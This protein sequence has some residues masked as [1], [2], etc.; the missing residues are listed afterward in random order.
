MTITKNRLQKLA[1]L[2]VEQK[3]E[4]SSPES[5]SPSREDEEEEYARHKN[6]EQDNGEENLP[7]EPGFYW[8][9][10][11]HDGDGWIVVD[12]V[13]EGADAFEVNIPGSDE[14]YLV[15]KPGKEVPEWKRS[16]AEESGLT[17]KFIGPLTPPGE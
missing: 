5:L 4:D 12:V 10:S 16:L 7:T 8:Y 13:M 9:R 1:G 3:E 17:G 2:L 14:F 6:K 15:L 11:S